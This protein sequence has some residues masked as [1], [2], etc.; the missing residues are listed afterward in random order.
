MDSTIKRKLFPILSFLLLLAQLLFVQS[1][2]AQEQNVLEQQVTVDV[3]AETVFAARQQAFGEARKKAW[4]QLLGEMVSSQAQQAQAAKLSDEDIEQFVSSISVISEQ[5]TDVRYKA[6]FAVEFA[7]SAVRQYLE[8]RG[9]GYTLPTP[10]RVL[11]PLFIDRNNNVLIWESSNP[12]RQ[13]WES[14]AGEIPLILPLGDGLDLMDVN[15][16]GTTEPAI[17]TLAERY[18]A[19]GAVF[20][21]VREDKDAQF[22]SVQYKIYPTN[23]AAT[24]NGRF[25]ADTLSQAVDILIETLKAVQAGSADSPTA[26]DNAYVYDTGEID[27]YAVLDA[28]EDAAVD[29]FTN[30]SASDNPALPSDVLSYDDPMPGSADTFQASSG[31]LLPSQMEQQQP[32]YADGLTDPNAAYTPPSREFSAKPVETTSIGSVPSAAS[33]SSGYTPPTKTNNYAVIVEL[34]P[35]DSWLQIQRRLRDL[36]LIRDVRPVYLGS[37]RAQVML[38]VAAGE[39]EFRQTLIAAGFK[40][41]DDWVLRY[42]G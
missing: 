3:S 12:W 22:V 29:P 1:A 31:Q 5:T 28:A 8:N 10:K 35:G 6:T 15:T 18:G 24:A 38:S 25:V 37:E 4:Q 2:W 41:S 13:A 33:T 16:A 21:T 11:I 30:Q 7:D 36:S 40:V 42:G 20:T 19:D 39:Q 32:K 34:S 23:G 26:D 9:I 14:Y 27:E 17:M